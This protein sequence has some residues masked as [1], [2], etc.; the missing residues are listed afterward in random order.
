[1]TDAFDMTDKV[2]VVTGGSRGLGKSMVEAF[3]ARGADVVITSRKL[4]AC[5]MLAQSVTETTGRRALGVA[6]HVGHWDQCDALFDTVYS[7]F[8]KCDVLVNNAGMSPLYDSLGEVTEGLF[9]KVID[10]NLKGPF[11]LSA[12]FGE[13]MAADGGGSIINVSSIA[14]VKPSPA[15][16]AYGAAKA[17]INNLTVSF[18]QAL[19][20]NVRVNTIMPGPFMTDISKAWDLEAFGEMAKREIPLQRGGEPEEVVG[21]ALYFA[22]AASSYT[23]GSVLK[24]DGGT[25][26]SPA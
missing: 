8:G 11:R 22:S 16:A 17:G 12:K 26:H 24:I 23:T 19:G 14:A 6:C 9:Q 15:E 1:M 20:P 4:P 25:A 13:R 18:A 7:E 21:A 10:V 2:V 3:A 5:E